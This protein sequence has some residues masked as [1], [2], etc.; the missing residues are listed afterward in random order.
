MEADEMIG[1]PKYG[2]TSW[3]SRGFE[4]LLYDLAQPPNRGLVFDVIIVGSGYGGAIAAA[5]LA[6]CKVRDTETSPERDIRVCL[7]ERGKEY[8][9]GMFPSR[10]VDVAGHVR[11]NTFYSAQ[12]RGRR[13]GLFDVR[14]GE[15][16]NAVLAN[17]LGGGSLIN[18]GVM[19][20][21][22]PTA[23]QG[24]PGDP[25][26]LDQA[27]GEVGKSLGVHR[28]FAA[29]PQE[30]W[31]AKLKALQEL[32][33]ATAEF[34]G[35]SI[36][37]ALEAGLNGEKV[38]LQTCRRC[39]DCAT[40]CNQDAKNSLDVNLLAGA[41]RAGAQIFTGATVLRIERS[42]DRLWLVHTVHTDEA[43][44]KGQSEPAL[45]RAHKVI[46]AAGTFGSTEILMRSESDSLRFSRCL[47]QRFSAN[48]DAI[49][50]VYDQGRRVNAVADESIPLRLREVGPTITGMIDLRE[51]D[52]YVV[53]ELAVPAPLR[54]LFEETVTTANTLHCLQDPDDTE[55][56]PDE[57]RH[58]PCAVDARAIANSSLLVILGDDGARGS[59]ELVGGKSKEEG[60]GAIRVRWPGLRD[61]EL[62]AKQFETLQRLANGK[63]VLPNPVWQ[64]LP[65]SMQFL[66]DNRRGPPLTVHPLG[67]CPMGG[68]AD[69]GVVNH[70]GQVFEATPDAD[71]EWEK[72]LVVLDGSIIP[73]ALGINPALTIAAVA[74]RAVR[75][76]RSEWKFR[77]PQKSDPDPEVRHRF[78]HPPPRE[79]ARPT[80]IE[81]MERMS[82][83][84]TLRRRGGGELACRVELTL[85]FRPRTIA[86]LVLPVK[87]RP[88]PMARTLKV[89]AGTLRVFRKDQWDEWR[90]RGGAEREL[91]DLAELCVPVSG[92]LTLLRREATTSG[93]RR[94]SA[95]RAWLRNRGLRDTWQAAVK[96]WR[97][98]RFLRGSSRRGVHDDPN[99]KSLREDICERWRSARALASRAGEV[100]TLEYELELTPGG[101]CKPGASLDAS[102]FLTG[103]RVAGLKR[104]T[105]GRKSNPWRQLME[106][107]LRRFPGLAG[108]PV[109]ELDTRFLADQRVPLMKIVTQNDQVSA[110]ADLASL[111]GYFLRLLLNVHIWSFRRPDEAVAREPQRLPGRIKRFIRRLPE[112]VIKEIDVD[113][114]R[115][116]TPVRVRL[117][118]YRP[119]TAAGRPVVM[120]HG[121]SASGTTF[122]HAAV[123]PNMAEHFCGRHRDVWILDLRTSSGMPT[124]RH[125]WAF[126]DAALADIPAA[127]DAICRET[128]WPSV[129]VFAH[130]MGAAMFSMAVLAPP[131]PG[132]PFF[133]EREELP[134][135][136]KR[137]VLSQIAPIVVMSPANAFRGY[138]MSYLRHF[139]PFANYQFRVGPDPGLADQLID[140]LLATLPYP[141]EEF[142]V[143]NPPWPWRRTP[144]VGTRHRMDALYGRDF[145]LA[146]KNGR[147]RLKR[148][149]LEH[150]D[151]LFGPLSIETVAQGIHF[152]RCE[153]LTNRAGRNLYTLPKNLHRWRF[154]TA[155]IHGEDNGL[156]DVATLARFESVFRE[157]G[158]KIVPK[159]FAGFGHQDCLIG[160]DA[161]TV[162]EYVFDFLAGKIG[163]A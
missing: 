106:M 69:S 159:R 127:I 75:S 100:R 113:E 33:G 86:A 59:L 142:R 45:L 66:F 37:I 105:Y 11:F 102:L 85:H 27:F 31:P 68:S 36:S 88:V 158:I 8:L 163:D 1:A 42:G 97:Q 28:G 16:V 73:N 76:L 90:R 149:V 111:F 133:R 94:C 56:R 124:A 141:Q 55:H 81:L 138:A 60:D 29:Y 120:I 132:E 146:D 13:E 15:D 71:K 119:R 125:P 64:L 53:E 65:K 148:K 92:T 108:P 26:E 140:R 84:A 122:A 110:L 139:L 62:F 61:D 41:R 7:L 18:A 83:D 137:A 103:A 87:N 104:L 160:R 79:K 6:G 153:L 128:R 116:G 156:S 35:A 52:G 161:E 12:P 20:R 3:L 162:F 57:P 5:E 4:E 129:D 155:S 72:S 118:R 80:R 39:G 63:K 126:E 101:M 136:I 131:K 151:D 144:F 89:A 40:G 32:A 9:P 117:T 93:Q 21:P 67:G 19:E 50:V 34:R 95:L 25:K 2:E 30:K 150:I 49:A 51:K 70:L 135:R 107:E 109:L 152:A 78:R 99:E 46:L 10:L 22:L 115:D 54:R 74:L 23:Y 24:W 112:P 145:S 44:R 43:L 48:G 77:E 91:D 14:V 114:L 98:G 47:G 96:R 38:A 154:P 134:R 121:Y 147:P 82:G 17:G 58:D 143:E 123:K 130:C 157:H